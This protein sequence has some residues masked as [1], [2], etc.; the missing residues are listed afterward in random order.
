MDD[1]I[2]PI[3][4]KDDNWPV[5]A[6]RMTAFLRIKRLDEHITSALP[7]DANADAKA[8]DKQAAGYIMCS[9]SEKY[10]NMLDEEASAYE[11]WSTLRDIFSRQDTARWLDYRMK[12]SGLTKK[13]EESISDYVARAQEISGALTNIGKPV[14]E[15]EVVGQLLQGLSEDYEVWRAIMRRSAEAELT[16]GNFLNLMLEAENTLKRQ[17]RFIDP[18]LTAT[19][20][21][22]SAGR[23]VQKF[24]RSA[25]AARISQQKCY[26]CDEAGHFAKD[27]P[28]RAQDEEAAERL[29][30]YKAESSGSNNMRSAVATIAFANTSRK[31]AMLEAQGYYFDEPY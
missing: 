24:G 21:Y 10:L 11:V 1:K 6:K 23:S 19:A 26:Y 9:I 16:Y 29:K 13:G 20:M 22:S 3:V 5:F 15:A 7:D 12:L 8:K 18:S 2:P 4:L 17:G 31:E 28:M 30:K 27:C 25:R 14:E